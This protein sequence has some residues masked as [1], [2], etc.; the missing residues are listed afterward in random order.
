MLFFNRGQRLEDFL[1][2]DEL[3]EAAKTSLQPRAEYDTFGS[4]A[5]ELAKKAAAAEAA[6][7]AGLNLVPE[8]IIAPVADSMGGC[9]L[10]RTSRVS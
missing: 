3:A 4:T 8:E 9:S 6:G 10:Q 2:E 1:D 7:G 5:A